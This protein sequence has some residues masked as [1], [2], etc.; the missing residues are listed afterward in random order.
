MVNWEREEAGGEENNAESGRSRRTRNII[1]SIL[2]NNKE[3][4]DNDQ[5]NGQLTCQLYNRPNWL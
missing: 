1:Q 5:T 2:R 3:S 4:G